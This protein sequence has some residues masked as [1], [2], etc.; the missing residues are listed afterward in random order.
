MGLCRPLAGGSPLIDVQQLAVTS[1]A[2]GLRVMGAASLLRLPDTP[3]VS[4]PLRMT[5]SPVMLSLAA[6]GAACEPAVLRPSSR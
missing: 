3:R 2:T 6:R 1:L 4:V 5:N